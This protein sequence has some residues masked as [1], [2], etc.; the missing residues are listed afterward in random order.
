MNGQESRPSSKKRVSP[1]ATTGPQ[2]CILRW[3]AHHVL[4]L[5]NLLQPQNFGRL[6]PP[7]EVEARFFRGSSC[8]LGVHAGGDGGDLGTCTLQSTIYGHGWHYCY[9]DHWFPGP[10]TTPTSNKLEIS[11]CR[12]F[13]YIY[14]SPELDF[15]M[16]TAP[17]IAL[18]T[19]HVGSCFFLRACV[20]RGISA[21]LHSSKWL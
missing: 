18:Q 3:L 19:L 16:Y 12:G 6:I 1:P 4:S 10:L 17:S 8:P 21:V 11:P 14:S 2:R 5:S 13:K 9:A 15:P 20:Q 7:G